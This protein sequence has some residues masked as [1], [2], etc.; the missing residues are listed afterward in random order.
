MVLLRFQVSL[1]RRTAACN[2]A[3]DCCD[4]EAMSWTTTAGGY[5]GDVVRDFMLAAVE[6]VSGAFGKHLHKSSG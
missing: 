5:S 1:R 6:I 3:L 4:R 2:Y